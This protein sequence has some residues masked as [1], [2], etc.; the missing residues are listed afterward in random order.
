ML[1]RLLG[2]ASVGF[3]LAGLWLAG[4]ALWDLARGRFDAWDETLV[5][6]LSLLS[7]LLFLA[8]AWRLRAAARR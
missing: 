2:A 5:H 1:E 7:G 3:L 8:A 4:G 6:G